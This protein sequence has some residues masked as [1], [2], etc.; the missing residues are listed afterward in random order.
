M[1]DSNATVSLIKTHN[2]AKLPVFAHNTDACG[3]LY[4]VEEVVVP[5]NK[6]KC[7]DIGWKLGGI[8]DPDW[9]LRI[10]C[11]SGYGK[12]G[13]LIPNGVGIV[14]SGYRGSIGVL[15]YNS[16][17]EDYV[18]HPGDRVAQISLEK[19]YRPYFTVI[20]EEEALPSDRDG[21]FG[22]TGV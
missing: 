8:S 10:F 16:T 17:D 1:L 2:N 20:E 6:I 19:V 14:D 11:R 4:S 22:S 7:V 3:D 5:P 15:L 12:R 21:G 9:Q 18:V 13:I